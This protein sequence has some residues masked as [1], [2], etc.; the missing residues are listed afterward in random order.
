[1]TAPKR[2]RRIRQRGWRKPENAVIVDRTSR[3]G[4]PWRVGDPGVPDRAAAVQQFALG[5]AVRRIIIA[6]AV[7]PAEVLKSHR[8]GSYPSDEEIRE[9]LRG[10]D[11]AC[12]CP[13]PGPGETDHCH[14]RILLE[15]AAGGED[16]A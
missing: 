6:T 2:I 1:M 14:A 9:R 10:K 12:P 4:N 3:Y 11:L 15:L 8:L 13:L 7:D 16:R 5:L